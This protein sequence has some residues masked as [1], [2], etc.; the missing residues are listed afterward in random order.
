MTPFQEF[1]LWLKRAPSG[2]RMATGVAFALVLAV[3]AWLFVPQV[4]STGEGEQLGGPAAGAEGSAVVPG[5]AGVPGATNHEA[6]GAVTGGSPVGG[7]VSTT[8]TGTGPVAPS[9]SGKSPGAGPGLAT[10][11]VK[12]G[13]SC[14]PGSAPGVSD[15]RIKVAVIIVSIA[16]PAANS[17]FGVASPEQQR[18]FYNAAIDDVNARGGAGCRQIVP[19]FFEAN[20]ADQSNL[21]Q[22]CID[23]AQ[24]GVFAVLDTGAYAQF[25]LVDCYGRNKIP[26]FGSYLVSSVLQATYYPYLFNFNTI[27]RLHRD[28]VFA[29]RDRGFFTGADVKKLGFLYRDCDD[30]LIRSIRGWIRE[31]GLPDSKLVTYDLGCPTALASPGDMQQAVLK[32]QQEGVTN[33]TTAGLQADFASFT[34]IAQQQRFKPK[35]G[36]PNDSVVS[37]TDGAQPPDFDNIDGAV[38]VTA[39]RYGDDRTPGTTMSPGTVRCNAVLKKRGMAPVYEQPA[40]AGNTCSNV[41]MFDAAVDRAPALQRNALAAGLQ[42]A[43]SVEL[44]FPQGPNDFSGARVTTAGQFWRPL[45]F[46]KA[47]K[48]WRLLDRKF[49]PSYS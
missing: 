8:K 26:Y 24:A 5:Q 42:A 7:T 23:I 21:H 32:F 15:K 2:D 40:A 10:G 31:S 20:P 13:A 29:L 47:C 44:S 30:A 6:G 3:M 36:L 1:R 27:E 4:A 43:K 35:Y 14:P 48:C 33:M 37:G 9:G 45:E 46:T 49:K 17:V 19:Q 22:T 41:W 25:P 16:G 28:T 18:A 39:N 12:G 11:A 38:A 34:R